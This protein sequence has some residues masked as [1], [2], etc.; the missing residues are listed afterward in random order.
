[1]VKMVIRKSIVFII[2][3]FLL[4]GCSFVNNE[5]VEELGQKIVLEKHKV[6]VNFYKFLLEN[7]YEVD[8]ITNMTLSEN[9]VS[10][11]F[12][13]KKT[14]NV[15]WRYINIDNPTT[16]EIISKRNP[17]YVRDIVNVLAFHDSDIDQ[18]EKEEYINEF[19]EHFEEEVTSFDLRS[20]RFTVTINHDL[21]NVVSNY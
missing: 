14:I 9:D 13:L 8:D 15:R 19:H 12:T 18:S 20:G 5:K 10:L 7:N 21:I 17:S 3:L 4:S 11:S 16:L 6:I 1:M 2:F